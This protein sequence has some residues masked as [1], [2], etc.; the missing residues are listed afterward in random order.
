[1]KKGEGYEK[2][3]YNYSCSNGNSVRSRRGAVAFNAD[4]IFPEKIDS[5]FSVSYEGITAKSID[6]GVSVH[7]PSIIKGEDGRYYIF[8]SHMSGAVT[9]D[10]KNWESI[11]DGASYPPGK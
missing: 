4:K 5:D 6:A 10:L 11:G 8:G 1:M 7:D 2:K 3:E 9:D